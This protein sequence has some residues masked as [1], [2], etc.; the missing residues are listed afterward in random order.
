M[1]NSR[2]CTS[3]L[4]LLVLAGAAEAHEGWGV[5]SAPGGRIYF[6]DVQR[7]IV[8]RLEPDGRLEPALEEVCAHALVTIADGSVYGAGTSG[9]PPAGRAWRIDPDGRVHVL[10]AA[11]ERGPGFRSFLIDTDGTIYSSAPGAAGQADLLRRRPGGAIDRVAG[12]FTAIDGM[13]WSPDGA[14]LLTDGPHLKY[15]SADGTVETLGGGAL[16][17]PRGSA[18]LAGVTTDGSGGAFVA[19]FAG[20]RL[21]DVGRRSG[22]AV[23]Y[24][25]DAPWSPAGVA[26]DAQGLVVLEHL[27][28]RWSRLARLQVG[29]YLRVRRLGVDGQVI[30][31]AVLW[32]TRSWIA[33]AGVVLAAA[34]AIGW[35]IARYRRTDY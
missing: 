8:W 14:I 28:P 17:E 11:A 13:A 27:A 5:V 35:H 34:A 15:V 1:A 24:A 33:G 23:E 16:S 30:T 32:G 6:T 10:A 19:D 9:D 4:L 26:R 7:R 18:D 22:V 31:L 20:G 2:F 29:P 12:G 3:S 21:L 25:S